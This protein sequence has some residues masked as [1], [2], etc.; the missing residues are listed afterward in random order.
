MGGEFYI[1][2]FDLRRFLC[3]SANRYKG[4]PM[5]NMRNNFGVKGVSKPAASFFCNLKKPVDTTMVKRVQNIF[6]GIENV[7]VCCVDAQ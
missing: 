5:K 6:R 3:Q 4:K 2:L 1:P 7:K